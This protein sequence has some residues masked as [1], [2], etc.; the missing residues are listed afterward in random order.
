MEKKKTK[1]RKELT[2]NKINPAHE[3]FIREYVDNLGNGV[4]AYMK[5]FP[6]ASYETARR[7]ASLLMSK[8]DIMEAIRKQY[9]KYFDG[10]DSKLEKTKTY[11]LIHS[12]GTTEISEVL[13]MEDGIFEVKK[14]SQIPPSAKH[15]I[16][17]IKRI[18]KDTAYGMDE[19][20]EIQ[21]HDKLQA[22][23]VRAKMQ[24]LLDS[25]EDAPELKITIQTAIRPDHRPDQENKKVK[26][27][28]KNANLL[29]SLLETVS[30]K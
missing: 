29:P 25:K 9:D 20:Y 11:R 21:M 7:K 24:K 23:I 16:K 2:K 15:A 27:G 10:M 13:D 18:R 19:H 1:K 28:D 14:L 12:I 3:I 22:L 5:A 6:K 30:I 8:G 26:Q 4:Q 17:T